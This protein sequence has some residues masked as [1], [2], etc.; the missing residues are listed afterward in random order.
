MIVALTGGIG[1][2]KSE[3]TKIF[4]ELNVPIVDLDVISHELTAANKPLVNEIVNQFGA[5]YRTPDGAL[6]RDAMRKL[7]F[8]NEAALKEL[9]AISHPAIY[10]QAIKQLSK[11]THAPYI[12]LAIPLLNQGTQYISFIDQ[13]LV[14]DCD[15][16]IQIERVRLRSQL[17]ESEVLKIIHAQTS[18]HDLLKLADDVIV[19]NGTVAELRIKI[20]HQHQKYINTCLV[21][22]TI[23]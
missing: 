2:G 10:D 1:C 12:I 20:Q 9:N 18:R 4:A 7:V 14:I 23:S 11:Y 6:N 8:N 16:K 5:I 3:A 22:K 19:N 17:T 15:E 21:S 13:I